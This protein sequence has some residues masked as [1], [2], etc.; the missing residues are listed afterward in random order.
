MTAA[1]TTVARRVK[2]EQLMYW[3]NPAAAGFTFAFPVMFLIIFAAINGNDR[4]HLQ[5]GTVRFAQY[6]VPGIVAFGIISA[7]YTN[8]AITLTFRR[9]LGILKRTRGTPVAPGLYFA[10]IIGN[11]V[12][13]SLIIAGLTM[14]LGV[15]AYGVT[16]PGRYLGLVV[17]IAL[18]AF[19]FS[20]LGVAITTFV[21][22]EEAAPAI[23]NFLLFPLLF[24]SG[25]FNPIA[26]S[27]GLAR[28]ADLFPVRHA[29]QQMLAVFNP[30]GSGTGIVLSHS[31]VMLAWGIVGVVL[32]VRRFKWEPVRR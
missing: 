19:C 32:S 28:F 12:V 25:T 18:A 24:I 26:A 4:V 14:A 7:C 5:G 2:W 13:I 29:L 30:F 23:I 3:R 10:G 31:L 22:N 8:L 21:P 27:S 1:A 6:F 9:Q 11:V 16:F 17:T 15:V 20:G